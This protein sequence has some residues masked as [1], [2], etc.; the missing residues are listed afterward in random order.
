MT[1][2][3]QMVLN[4]AAEVG[5]KYKTLRLRKISAGTGLSGGGDLSADITLSLSSATQASLGRADTALQSGAQGPPGGFRLLD[6]GVT[7]PPSDAQ[8]G[9][10]IGYR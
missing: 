4:L 7:T 3:V 1:S 9:T 8:P 2:P 5:A 10:L 6:P